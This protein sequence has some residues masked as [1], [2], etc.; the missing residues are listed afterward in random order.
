[1]W[2][3]DSYYAQGEGVERASL[4]ARDALALAQARDVARLD[5]AHVEH[6]RWGHLH[7]TGL[8]LLVG[9]RTPRKAW[10]LFSVGSSWVR[11]S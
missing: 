5:A 9:E 7:C 6:R 1:M 10:F 2:V 3:P 8:N 11:R 4:L